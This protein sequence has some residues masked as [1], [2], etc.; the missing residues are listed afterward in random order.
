[1]SAMRAV[2]AIWATTRVNANDVA[3]T[4]RDQRERL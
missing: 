2:R 4:G 3:P 1:M